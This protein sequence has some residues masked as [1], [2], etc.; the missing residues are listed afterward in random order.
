MRFSRLL[1]LALVVGVVGLAG[2]G[3]GSEDALAP[4]A[5]D[6][7]SA[8]G[9]RVAALVQARYDRIRDLEAEFEQTTYSVT[10]G[11]GSVGSPEPSRGR[12]I[13]AK[14]GKMR[15]SYEHPEPSLVVS[16]GVTLWLYNVGLKEA[17]RLSVTEGYLTGAALQFLLGEGRLLKEFAVAARGCG[18]GEVELELVP[19]A[20]ASYDR[21]GLVAQEGTGEIVSTTIV[22][23]FG[24]QTRIS[25][26]N[27][28][29]NLDPPAK[30]FVFDVPP[31]AE[32]ID[33]TAPQP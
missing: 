9:E 2:P 7:D 1:F 15:W 27:L 3:S 30:T 25:F 26:E 5:V 20:P 28:R 21:L 8:C 14:P 10:L 17:S 31:D 4:D 16:D 29:T 11:T 22:D 19:V 23:L 32:V 13:F 6:V 33:V 24:N 12:V 18:S